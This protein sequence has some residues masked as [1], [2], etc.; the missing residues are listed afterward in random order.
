MVNSHCY[1]FRCENGEGKFIELQLS[2][3]EPEHQ[4]TLAC[5]YNYHK[6]LFREETSSVIHFKYYKT[7][8]MNN[9]IKCKVSENCITLNVKECSDLEETVKFILEKQERNPEEKLNIMFEVMMQD[10]RELKEK[11]WFTDKDLNKFSEKYISNWNSLTNNYSKNVDNPSIR[12]NQDSNYDVKNYAVNTSGFKANGYTKGCR[13]ENLE[14]IVIYFKQKV[15][16]SKIEFI[17]N[18]PGKKEDPIAIYIYGVFK[19]QGFIRKMEE[20]GS[21]SG[22]S[23]PKEEF[24][25]MPKLEQ[26][27]KEDC[28]QSDIVSV[29][30]NLSNCYDGIGIAVRKDKT[31]I[32]YSLTDVRIY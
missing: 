6:Y 14:P 31:A 25:I 28:K 9:S 15:E 18:A 1:S 17:V 24:I 13:E 10:I 7:C 8:L 20:S 32:S 3:S 21:S 5:T 4:I 16:F 22:T 26:L 12:K 23:E 30:L 11:L 2:F 19:P 27:V 29:S